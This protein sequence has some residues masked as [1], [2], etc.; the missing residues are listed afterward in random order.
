MMNELIAVS[1]RMQEKGTYH[2]TFFDIASNSEDSVRPC[3]LAFAT[4]IN[5]VKQR[6]ANSYNSLSMH[7]REC[8]TYDDVCNGQ[9]DKAKLLQ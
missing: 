7:M 2:T 9:V 3:S 5:R 1:T 8:A 4:N 6:H